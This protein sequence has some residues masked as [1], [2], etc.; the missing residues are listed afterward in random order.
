M[1]YDLS[2]AKKAGMKTVYVYRWT[3]DVREDQEVVKGENE[4]WLGDM[5]GLGNGI[6]QLG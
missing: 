4:V 5:R 2:G 1:H 3:D 6:E